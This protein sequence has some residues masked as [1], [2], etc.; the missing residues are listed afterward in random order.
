MNLLLLHVTLLENTEQLY[1]VNFAGLQYLSLKYGFHLVPPSQQKV[2]IYKM[3]VKVGNT[4]QYVNLQARGAH[5]MCEGC[6]SPVKRRV[7]PPPLKTANAFYGRQLIPRTDIHAD[8]CMIYGMN[9]SCMFK[10]KRCDWPY[11]FFLF[12]G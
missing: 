9:K 12:T 10:L 1:F 4:K 3:R 2:N 8:F 7:V 11:N 5:L 6:I